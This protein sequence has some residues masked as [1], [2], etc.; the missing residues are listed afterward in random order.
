MNHKDR[1]ELCKVKLKAAPILTVVVVTLI[2]AAIIVLVEA[3]F[4][5]LPNY[6]ALMEHSSWLLA[7]LV[8]IPQFLIPL[9]LIVYITKGRLGEYG[10]NLREKPPFFTHGRMLGLGVFFG[11]LMSLSYIRQVVAGA[12]L[13]IP[14]PVTTTSVVGNLAFQWIVVG[15]SEETMFRGF[16]QTHLMKHLQGYVKIVGHDLHIG[17]VIAAIIWGAFHFINILVMPLDTV[18]FF[19]VLTTLM[20][21]PMGYAYQ[22]TRSLLTTVIVHNTIFGVPLTVGYILYW[23]L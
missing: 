12:P 1:K 22:E 14:R 13:D 21:L 6:Q 9:L 15:L 8:H 16:I 11:L 4:R 3:S 23:L 7:V 5:S 10:F 19:V 18:V 2:V 20:G 17:T